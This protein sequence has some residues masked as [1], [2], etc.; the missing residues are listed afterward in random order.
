MPSTQGCVS[1]GSLTYQR[2]P[3]QETFIC[4]ISSER[5]ANLLQVNGEGQTLVLSLKQPRRKQG[6]NADNEMEVWTAMSLWPVVRYIQL[7]NL[8][9][10][11][12]MW[13]NQLVS[14]IVSAFYHCK[15]SGAVISITYAIMILMVHTL[16]HFVLVDKILNYM[17]VWFW[18][19]IRQSFTFL[20]G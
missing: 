8:S 1:D 3:R 15:R 4:K 7:R 10:T 19:Y 6:S 16:F 17:Y 9:K 2:L 18:D 12:A 5:P 20:L 13:L 11:G 14:K